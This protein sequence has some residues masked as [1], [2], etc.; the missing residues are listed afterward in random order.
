MSE[1]RRAKPP[2]GDPDRR[3]AGALGTATVEIKSGYG[4]TI[5]DELRALRIAGEFTGE[6]T[7]LGAHVVPAELV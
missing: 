2:V 6:S 4:L 5:A 7:F 3:A 1:A